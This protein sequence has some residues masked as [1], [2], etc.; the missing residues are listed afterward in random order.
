MLLRRK[1]ILVLAVLLGGG[2]VWGSL[3]YGLYLRSYGYRR[4]VTDNVSKF[5]KLPT[6]I[7]RVRPLTSREFTVDGVQVW[8]PDSKTR[9]FR[10]DTA[11]WQ[12]KRSTDDDRFMLDLKGGG[13]LIDHNAWS[14]RDYRHVLESGLGHNFD[15]LRLDEVRVHDVD[16]IWRRDNF[17]LVTEDASGV[18]L[19]TGKGRGQAA[20]VSNTLNDRVLDQPIHIRSLFHT[21]P[22]L[23]I[24]E[25]QLE[26]P[27]IPIAALSLE[28]ML[29][30]AVQEGSFEGQILYRE[31]ENGDMVRI[32]GS[33]DDVLLEDLTR[34]W[35]RVPLRGRVSLFIE[36][37]VAVNKTFQ[38]GVVRGTVS[39]VAFSPIWTLAGLPDVGGTGTI[40]ILR[41]DVK[42]GRLA[43]L[44]VNGSAGGLALAPLCRL[45]GRGEITGTINIQ[46]ESA[47]IID[48][49]LVAAELTVTAVPPEGGKGTI[50][51]ALLKTVAEQLLGF[52]VPDVIPERVEYTQFGAKLL[53]EAGRLRVLG[54]HGRKNRTILTVR[55]LGREIGVLYQ[56]SA[57]FDVQPWVDQLKAK[58]DAVR[59]ET[60]RDWAAE[61]TTGNLF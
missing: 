44:R 43:S 54:S 26:A 58:L 21:Q 59:P 24:D 17:A 2:S 9:I 22:I 10:C 20:L 48:N 61:F 56:P 19:F 8:L 32:T 30:G 36:D 18:V 13:F 12:A 11:A 52:P 23:T 51:R 46:L 41:A 37:A 28:H 47:T 49:Q 39:D 3:A 1:L 60:V 7:D 34:K 35:L 33:L 40:E 38:R 55:L 50:D 42:A 14:R 31:T 57:T 5:L 15:E 6:S 4:R 29:G 27:R 53:L 45:F 25:V 16:F